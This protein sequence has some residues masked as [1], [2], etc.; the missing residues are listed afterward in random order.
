M[1]CSICGGSY[2]FPVYVREFEQKDVWE[3]VDGGGGS[4]KTTKSFWTGRVIPICPHCGSNS[5]A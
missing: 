1:K 3:D 5:N 4:Y 2:N